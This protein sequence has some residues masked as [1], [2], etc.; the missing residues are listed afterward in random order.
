MDNSTSTHVNNVWTS[1]A[2]SKGNFNEV[3]NDSSIHSIRILFYI[4]IKELEGGKKMV[5][6]F[7]IINWLLVIPA[8]LSSETKI[9][10][11]ITTIQIIV[12]ILQIVY[13][14]LKF[15]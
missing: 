7:A 8:C 10:L 2:I 13:V 14:C 5:W 1:R 3:S 15:K 4:Y 12:A 11:I 6:M 9:K